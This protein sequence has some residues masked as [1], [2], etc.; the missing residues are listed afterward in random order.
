MLASFNRIA[1]AAQAK[2][3]D[4]VARS[5]TVFPDRYRQE[6]ARLTELMPKW[7]HTGWFENVSQKLYKVI[8]ILYLS[9][10]HTFYN[11]MEF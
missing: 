2:K 8:L 11:V 9:R 7:Q 4:S 6:T 5:R 1:T 3:I 10:K